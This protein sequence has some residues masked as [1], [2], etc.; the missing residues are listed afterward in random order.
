M[1]TAKILDEKSNQTRIY[2]EIFA[3][4]QQISKDCS[5]CL[6]KFVRSHCK[7]LKLIHHPQNKK[8]I[9]PDLFVTRPK[10]DLSCCTLF[11]AHILS[12]NSSKVFRVIFH[13]K[14]QIF[15]RFNVLSI[16]RRY[17]YKCS[18]RCKNRRSFDQQKVIFAGEI[19]ILHSK[20][21]T[22]WQISLKDCRNPQCKQTPDNK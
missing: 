4:H 11:Y 6:K 12:L 21:V 22:C 10:Y 9:L 7:H 19:F 3:F 5:F 1:Q 16:W 2:N 15:R 13:I 18:W 8:N 17:I 14:A 20:Y